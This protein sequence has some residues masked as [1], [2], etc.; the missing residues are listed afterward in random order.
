M[1]VPIEVKSADHFILFDVTSSSLMKSII[2]PPT[3]GKKII[4][5]SKGQSII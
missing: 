1:N 5:D 4:T 3:R 2:I